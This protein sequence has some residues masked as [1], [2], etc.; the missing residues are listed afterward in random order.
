[1]F[2]PRLLIYVSIFSNLPSLPRLQFNLR[3]SKASKTQALIYRVMLITP[4]LIQRENRLQLIKLRGKNF[5]ILICFKLFYINEML[6]KTGNT[7]KD[8]V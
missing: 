7:L 1:M 6:R 4:L 2:S 5:E 3:R 8:L